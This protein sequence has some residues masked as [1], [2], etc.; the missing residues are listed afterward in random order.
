ML[1]RMLAAA[2]GVVWI[3]PAV[4]TGLALFAVGHV[5]AGVSM[6]PPLRRADPRSVWGSALLFGLLLLAV[7]W[8]PE[9]FRPFI[10][11]QF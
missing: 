1:A 11:F 10:Y 2:P 9:G 5:T 6:L 3:P 8:K 7:I 4:V